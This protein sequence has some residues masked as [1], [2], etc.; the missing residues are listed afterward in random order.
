MATK[1][2]DN[3]I[4][5]RAAL[6]PRFLWSTASIDVF[7]NNECILRTGGQLKFKG[8]NSNEFSYSGSAH[9]I[10]LSWGPCGILPRIPYKL[11][12]DGV[13]ISESRV[14]VRNWPVGVLVGII[15][16]AIYIFIRRTI[17]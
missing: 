14:R 3:Q 9:K 13:L 8:S 15:L 2:Q 7:L 5:V 6:I 1:W 10:E 4:D 11:Y 17:F 16:V 12:I